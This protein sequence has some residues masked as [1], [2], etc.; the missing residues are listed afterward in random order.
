M[1]YFK[2]Y[3]CY[4]LK[5]LDFLMFRWIRILH[6]HHLAQNM[7]IRL[8]WLAGHIRTLVWGDKILCLPFAMLLLV[9]FCISIFYWEYEFRVHN[10]Y[11]NLKMWIPHFIAIYW[12]C[13]NE[14]IIFKLRWWEQANFL[15]KNILLYFFDGLFFSL[16]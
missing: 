9:F 3:I 10:M 16:K 14:F 1:K 11:E 12:V 8:T 2:A 15:C 4:D 5:N 7:D 6:Y 13:H